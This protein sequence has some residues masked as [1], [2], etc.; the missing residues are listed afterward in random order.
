MRRVRLHD[1]EILYYISPEYGPWIS[2]CVE[3]NPDLSQAGMLKRQRA[4]N[5]LRQWNEPDIL[6]ADD[7]KKR[8]VGRQNTPFFL[9]GGGK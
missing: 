7:E 9:G 3:A 6:D 4:A 1:N 8:G 2:P 5:Q